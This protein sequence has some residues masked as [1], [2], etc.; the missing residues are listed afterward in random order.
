MAIMTMP[1]ESKNE[2]KFLDI[3]DKAFAEIEMYIRRRKDRFTS[4]TTDPHIAHERLGTN[5]KGRGFFLTVTPKNGMLAKEQSDILFD[6][7]RHILLV[8]GSGAGKG[9]S[10]IVP[11]LLKHLGSTVVYDPAGENYKLTAAYRQKVLGQKV[12]LIDPQ[13]VTGEISHTWNPLLEIDFHNDPQAFDKCF[14]LAE[15][16]IATTGGNRYFTDSSQECLAMVCAYAGLRSCPENMHLPQIHTLIQSGELEG[17]WHAMS[18]CEGLG[19]IVRRYAESNL[20]R[21]GEEFGSVIQTLRTALRFL[22]SS[23]MQTNLS[24]SSFSM[25][26]LKDGNTTIY[27]VNPAG[28][29]ETYNGWIRLMFDFAF[30][31]MQDLS[32]PN[33]EYSTLFL[34]DEF[35]LL[36][37]MERIKRAAGE[38]RKFG[39]KLM[40][41]CQDIPQL[42]E[43]YGD[44][45]ETFISNSG[46]TIFFANAD[47][48]TQRYLSEKL[49]KEF[50]KKTSYS[51]GG[52]HTLQGGAPS[53]STSYSHELRDVFRPDQIER[54]GSRNVGKAFFL[55]AGQKPICLPRAPY[56]KYNM[57]PKGL[58]YNPTLPLPDASS[59]APQNLMVAE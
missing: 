7:D 48:T 56:Y 6:D 16:L 29:G 42:K 39:V 27:I 26:D 59:V 50:Y 40:L 4:I 17:L 54:Q 46:L 22:S 14:M 20:A 52:S 41:C 36:G 24:S 43:C 57:I 53:N 12:I 35:P 19:G 45:W 38:A 1:H 23:S 47:L 44:A 8:G 31:A 34:I 33:P 25:K 2:T 55:I 21:E 37:R 15:S 3:I 30:D 9:T 58:K 51:S 5:N 18:L 28:A 11:N 13:G 32:L 10:I 49:G